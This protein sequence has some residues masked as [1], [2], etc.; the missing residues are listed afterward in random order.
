M[1]KI[2]ISVI[3]VAAII[4]VGLIAHNLQ[5]T[6][7]PQDKSIKLG[8]IAVLSGQY[9]M[10]GEN[11]VKGLN[12]AQEMY[13]KEH[14]DQK[15]SVVV[16]D[17]GYNATKGLSAY[18][19][20]TQVD[21]VDGLL[22]VS[23]LTMDAIY[24]RAKQANM[25]VVQGFEQGVDPTDD[26]VFQLFPGNMATEIALG[27][28]T[29][30]AGYKNV[31][32]FYANNAVY[33]RFMNAFEEGY[34]GA[35][36]LQKFPIA[37]DNHDYRTFVTKALATNPDAILFI[38]TPEQ[39]ALI[40]KT[41]REQTKHAYPFIFDANIQ[42]GFTEYKH[43]LGDTNIL[44]GSTVVVVRTHMNAEFVKNFKAKYGSEPGIATDLGYDSFN[45]ALRTHAD[46]GAEWIKNMKAASFEGV[47]GKIVFD[48]VG[49][50]TPDFGIEQIAGGK[51]PQ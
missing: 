50:R 43:L 17:D 46:S 29:K 16:E 31:A 38:A 8:V 36:T 18:E 48:A 3:T 4:V 15:V 34:G 39:G 13:A 37:I 24:A 28:H 33:I 6:T 30:N 7:S 45:F 27:A 26:N 44:N 19:K 14:P 21:K 42:T 20:L 41:I 47:G 35:G 12:L 51:F 1:N 11:Y 2:K 10:V 9:A 49:V 23:T 22:N 40:I 25:P 5:K 32:A